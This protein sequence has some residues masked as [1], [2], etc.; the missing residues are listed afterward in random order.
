MGLTPPSVLNA[1]DTS[2]GV[3]F[4]T[5]TNALEWLSKNGMVIYLLVILYEQMFLNTSGNN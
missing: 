3:P 2:T 4:G 5:G 1:A